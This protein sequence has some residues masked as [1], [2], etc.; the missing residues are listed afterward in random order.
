MKKD[1]DI[2]KISDSVGSSLRCMYALH[3]LLD[4]LEQ[5]HFDMPLS[6]AREEA[7]VV[8]VKEGS[9]WWMQ[10]HYTAVSSI[11]L[12]ANCLAENLEN[13]LVDL[14]DSIP[15]RMRLPEESA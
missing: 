6:A 10:N 11:V 9:F 2:Q 3:G 7:G 13:I 5:H 4:T 1:I 8:D 14:D 15:P 12:G